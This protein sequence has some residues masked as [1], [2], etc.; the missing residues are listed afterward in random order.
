MDTEAQSALLR[1]LE[2][3]PYPKRGNLIQ[4]GYFPSPDAELYGAMIARY[5]PSRIVEVGAGYST[6]VA[7]ATI[8][9]LDSDTELRVIDPEPRCPVEELADDVERC[10]V[11]SSTLASGGVEPDT[12][13]L[14]DSSHLV[15][16]GGDGPFL[17]CRL[18][19]SLPPGVLV[20]VHDVFLP[21]D[22][23]P[24]YRERLYAEQYLLHALL[25]GSRK[26]EIVFASYFMS[27]ERGESMRRAFGPDVATGE[28][29]GAS[30]WMRTVR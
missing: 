18:L 29:R 30:F 19:P 9:H 17:Y 27:A 11:E 8:D 4:N 16:A 7:R 10:R 26:F 20:H 2:V 5:R 6:A 12:L 22:Y 21:F 13:L 25:S 15:R 23:P 14:I 1:S 24:V 3:H 28:F